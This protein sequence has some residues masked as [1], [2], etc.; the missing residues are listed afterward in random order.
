MTSPSTEL[1]DI[2]PAVPELD[3]KNDSDTAEQV[4][5][6]RLDSLQEVVELP[7]DSKAAG[8][9]DAELTTKPERIQSAITHSVSV[10]LPAVD[11]LSD[12]QSKSQDYTT[13]EVTDSVDVKAAHVTTHAADSLAVADVHLVTEQVVDDQ[14][15]EETVEI[16]K[17]EG[18][19]VELLAEGRAE[20]SDETTP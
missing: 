13:D 4:T 11:N 18:S 9:K 10:E 14:R 12:T 6:S 15:V 8:S 3:T 7:D 17:S 5:E 20:V 1:A 16:D 19:N 2:Q